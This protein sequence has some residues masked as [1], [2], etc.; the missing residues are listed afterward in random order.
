MY[1]LWSW[2]II[3]VVDR[4]KYLR[5]KGFGYLVQLLSSEPPPLP[6]VWRSALGAFRVPPTVVAHIVAVPLT[7]GSRGPTVD[8]SPEPRPLSVRHA[9][10]TVIH[11]LKWELRHEVLLLELPGLRILDD[12]MPR[13]K[14]SLISMVR[15]GILFASSIFL[16]PVVLAML[17]SVQAERPI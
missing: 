11:V 12:P 2:N 15:C 13:I 4:R 9:V 16:T 8:V 1:I 10:L 14:V 7:Q 3:D 5:D 6:P 17:Y